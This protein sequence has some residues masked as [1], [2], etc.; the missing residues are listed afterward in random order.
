MDFENFSCQNRFLIFHSRNQESGK[1]DVKL[2]RDPDF[3][4]MVTQKIR[5]A[6][7]LS[8]IKD[9]EFRF[10]KTDVKKGHDRVVT[11]INYH[12]KSLKEIDIREGKSDENLTNEI[13]TE[14]C[15][16]VKLAVYH[17]KAIFEN[18]QF[19]VSKEPEECDIKGSYKY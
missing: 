15:W 7:D 2:T 13:T 16:K 1:K 19:E 14:L 8:N 17:Y 9:R 18:Q 6:F 4:N 11:S 12:M 5:A 3:V 10:T